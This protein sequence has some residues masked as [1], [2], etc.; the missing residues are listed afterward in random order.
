MPTNYTPHHDIE[1][2]RALAYL[3]AHPEIDS[4]VQHEWNAV[5]DPPGFKTFRFSVDAKVMENTLIRLA[6][7]AVRPMKPPPRT[8]G[9]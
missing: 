2:L 5:D 8:P 1:I 4:H 7:T 3:L 6:G 9:Y